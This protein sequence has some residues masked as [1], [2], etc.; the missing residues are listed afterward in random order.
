MRGAVQE[1]RTAVMILVEASWLDLSGVVQS[2][3][4]RMENHSAHGACI[5]MKARV[6]LGKRVYIQSH[7]EQFS[8]IAKYCRVD[9]KKF[10]VRIHRDTVNV[11]APRKP[12]PATVPARETVQ[13]SEVVATPVKLRDGPRQR[14][15]AQSE[16]RDAEWS[17]SRRPEPRRESVPH[18]GK[19][20]NG[21]V[22]HIA[23][24]EEPIA[25][26]LMEQGAR[27]RESSSSLPPASLRPR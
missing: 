23:R 5:R 15:N 25:A 6:A 8:G 9:G 24:I 17:A 27:N 11:A 12:A 4:A 13:P 21:H 26:R 10:L 1:S 16:M 22:G 20:H 3:T 2:V 19:G 7:R 14:A 18:R